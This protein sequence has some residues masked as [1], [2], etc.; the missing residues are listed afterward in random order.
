LNGLP[1]LSLVGL[2]LLP[3]VVL[4]EE[5]ALEAYPV[6]R[7]NITFILG[8]DTK[9][10]RRFYE[11]SEQYFRYDS[12]D[13][14]DHMVTSL[15]SL[16]EVR[17]YLEKNPPTNG[18]PWGLVNIVV[19]SNQWAGMNASVFLGGQRTTAQT[20]REALH[21]GEF[22]PLPDSLMDAISEIRVQGCALGKDRILLRL[23]AQA[24]GGDDQQHPTVRSS[25]L[26]S[27]FQADSSQSSGY[28]HGLANSWFVFLKPGT[29][30]SYEEIAARFKALYPKVKLNW[31]DALTREGP[32]FLGDAFSYKMRIPFRWTVVYPEQAAVPKIVTLNQKMAWLRSQKD[33]RN[34]LKKIGLSL[35]QFYWQVDPSFYQ[36][37]DGTDLPA[38]VARGKCKVVSVIRALTQPDPSNPKLLVP[39]KPAFDN[40]KFYGVVK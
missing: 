33:L 30:P 36:I 22:Q 37:E 38:V 7:E 10:T 24:F 11:L 39:M 40:P 13:R 27:Y 18:Q 6:V 2:I 9:Q 32:R 1:T 20:L 12:T 26:F 5:T 28:L 25:K 16:L 15:R 23:L 19:H 17:N 8:E 14:T 31:G 34:H 21:Q 35:D 3:I 4:A 29:W